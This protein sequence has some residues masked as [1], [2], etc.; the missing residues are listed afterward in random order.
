MFMRFAQWCVC[1]LAVAVVLTGVTGCRK[2]EPVKDTPK[3]EPAPKPEAKPEAKPTPKPEV[4]AK[5]K[6]DVEAKVQAK[7][8]KADAFDGKIDKIVS[9]C[10]SCNLNMDG[11][12]EHAL[13]VMGYTLYFCSPVCK[14]D[15]E[16]DTTKA[17]LAME[18]PGE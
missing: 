7:L 6:A 8:A 3:V 2:E 4:E 11:T 12:S 5:A 14:M 9:K 13:E 1:C 16:D 17:I 10:A 18:I 15:F